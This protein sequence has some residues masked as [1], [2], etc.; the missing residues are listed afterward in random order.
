[1]NPRLSNP[2]RAKAQS[3]RIIADGSRYLLALGLGVTLLAGCG[4]NGPQQARTAGKEAPV[5]T[6]IRVAGAG[7]ATGEWILGGRV[8]A[9]EEATVR[10]TI[11]AR[12]T[13][14]PVA[15][16]SAFHAGDALVIFGSIE[17]K[18]AVRSAAARAHAAQIRNAEAERQARRLD[19]LFVRGVV[20]LRDRDLARQD[21]Q[22]AAAELAAAVAASEQWR[23]GTI[24][25]APFDGTVVRRLIEPG[26]DVLSGQPLLEVYSSIGEEIAVALPESRAGALE[27]A[28]FDVQWGDGGPWLATRLVRSEGAL[29]AGTRTRT[30]YLRLDRGGDTPVRIRP[31]SFVR[32]RVDTPRSDAIVVPSTSLV[33]RGG[34]TGLFIVR[35]DRARLRWVRPGTETARGVEIMAGLDAG[36]AYALDPARLRDGVAVEA[37]P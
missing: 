25:R 23:A 7:Q 34:L 30:A 1:M 11:A 22:V 19:S 8:R 26:A 32:V 31:G 27:G 6:S 14:F 12:V 37:R 36:E 24:I 13:A 29:D 4:T 2:R 20:A 18:E 9:R 5:V 3:E 35:D 28:R 21:A 16:G 15:D 10:A 33:R 17:S